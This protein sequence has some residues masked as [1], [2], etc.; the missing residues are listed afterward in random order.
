MLK[1][2]MLPWC[3]TTVVSLS[4]CV[5]GGG[6]RCQL[7]LQPVELMVDIENRT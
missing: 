5:F 1:S 7:Q 3:W 6:Q 4:V 2:Y